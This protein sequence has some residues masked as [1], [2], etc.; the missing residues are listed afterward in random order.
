MEFITSIFSH[1][2]SAIAIVLV[3][4]GLIFI[5]ELGHFLAFRSLGV[6]VVTFSIGMGPKIWG[7]K[8][9][10]TTYQIA[11]FPFGGY[12][13]S[14]GEYSKEVEEIGFTQEEAVNNRPA[15]Q[16]MYFAFAGPFANLL[17]AWVIY[18]VLAFTNGMS[19]PLPQIGEMLP[20][21]PAVQAGL[22]EKDMITAIDGKNVSS[23]NEVPEIVNASNGQ[24]LTFSV[25]RNGSPLDI[26]ITPKK[27]P[28]TNIF[29]EEEIA[30][31]VGI[32]PLGSVKNIPL[33]FSESL[34]QGV[35]QSWN[36]TVITLT[37]LKKMI[38]GSVSAD[39]VGGPLLIGEMIAKQAE[40]GLV[41]VLLLAALI[42]VNLGLLNLLPIP[43][44]DGGLIFFCL[45]EMV[46]RRP[47]PEKLQ[48]RLMQAGAVLLICLMVFATFNDV[49]RWFK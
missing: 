6:G 28:R 40:N 19:V 36:M 41:S 30:W 2:D 49:M 7:V 39:S 5:H 10:K 38:T 27:M 48:E 37:G 26:V 23:W 29:G 31:L 45:V 14:V 3:L 22:M 1:L 13:S 34:K 24:P 9:G 15:W 44:L 32:Q 47:V 11:A 18:T 20:D 16:R 35:V 46:I 21:S 17:T 4:G 25:D 8:K 43:I 12:V 42:S 33:S